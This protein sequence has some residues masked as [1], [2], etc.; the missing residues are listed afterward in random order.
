MSFN[1]HKLQTTTTT[2]N[3][4]AT[5]T[6]INYLPKHLTM[7]TFSA[8]WLR[9]SVVS[10]LCRVKSTTGVINTCLISLL[11]LNLLILSQVYLAKTAGVLLI[12]HYKR[13]ANPPIPSSQQQFTSS[14]SNKRKR[15]Q[16]VL[17][18]RIEL[19]TFCVLSRCDNHYTTPTRTYYLSTQ[20]KLVSLLAILKH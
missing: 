6:H 18:P 14:I 10:V 9:S 16:K 20:L 17:T 3:H 13:Y 4:E 1:F 19:G 5:H 2:N 12:A 8:F 7:Y 15:K 11:F